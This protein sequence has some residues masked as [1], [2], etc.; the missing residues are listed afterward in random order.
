MQQIFPEIVSN[1]KIAE[2]VYEMKFFAAIFRQSR[3]PGSSSILLVEGCYLRRPMSV[4]DVE[5]GVPDARI[6]KVVGK[7]TEIMSRMQAGKTV[8]QYACPDSATATTSTR[9][10]E[11]PLLVGGGVGVPPMYHALPKN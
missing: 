10:G 8:D 5:N 7:G 4:C 2:N 11:R 9:A 3:A 6:Y 1:E